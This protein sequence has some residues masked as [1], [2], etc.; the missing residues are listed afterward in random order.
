MQ[1]KSYGTLPKGAIFF[2]PTLYITRALSHVA[3]F[4][5]SHAVVSIKKMWFMDKC[6][7]LFCGGWN[8]PDSPHLCLA[9][10]RCENLQSARGLARCKSGPAITWLVDVTI[11]CTI[12]QKQ[13]SISPPTSPVLRTKYFK[14]SLAMENADWTSH[15]TSI[16]GAWA[17]WRTCTPITGYFHDKRKT[18][19]EN[20]REVYY[21]LLKCSQRQCTSLPPIS[22]KSLTIKI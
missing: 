16:E 4:F 17:S 10:R 12:F 1:K 11:H 18:S 15:W 5:V 8:R 14:K 22:T 3:L 6:I 19:K 21:L 9:E 20:L 7:W 2:W 13:F